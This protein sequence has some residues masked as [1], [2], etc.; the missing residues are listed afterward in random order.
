MKKVYSLIVKL[1]SLLFKYRSLISFSIV[2][3]GVL[4]SDVLFHFYF[5]S[6]VDFLEKQFGILLEDHK[7]LDLQILL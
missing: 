2:L 3:I 7:Q 1:N 4:L 5:P 6:T